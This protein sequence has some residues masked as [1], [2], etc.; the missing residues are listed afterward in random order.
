[1]L[2]K[3]L[4]CAII[5]F[6]LRFTLGA[7]RYTT[8]EDFESGFVSLSS[9]NAEEDVQPDAWTLDSATPDSSLYCL[10]LT[11]NCYKL[12][13]ITPY[14]IDSTGIIQV[15]VKTS[16]EPRI[17]G[18][19]FTDGVHNILY[20]FAG[21]RILDIEVWI[22]VYQGAFSSGV[23]NT[24]QLPVASDWEAFWGYLPVINGIIYI[25]DLDGIS[26]RSVWFDNIIDIS[27]DLPVAPA[28]SITAS[29]SAKNTGVF[30]SST[31]FDPD[32]DTFTY[33]WS[34]GDSTYS[35]LPNPYH[36]YAVASAYPYTV[37]LKV[38]DDT[39]KVGF[40]ATEV[41]LETGTS[42][43]PVTLNFVGDIMLARKYEYPGG[44][45]P[46]L[47][48]NAIFAP[49]KPYFGDAA[50]IN[51]AN[52]EVV[53]ANVG[54]H[55]PTKS[56]Y[57]RG[58]PANVN[59]LVY[60]GI[61]V[62][63][64]ANNHTMDYGIE[65]YQQMQGLLN[66]AGIQYSGCGANS[67]EAYLP[68]FYNCRG[69]NIA[70]L[71][72]SDRTGQYNN[73]Q[74][75]L[76]A[77]YNKPGF[78]YMTPYYVEQQLQAVEGVAD[79]KIVEMHGGSEYSLTPGAGYDKD[80]NPFLE[81]TEDEDY[82]YRNDVPHQWDIA[83]RH[84]AI[85]SGAD[86]VIVHHPHIIQGL[87]LYQNKLIAHSLG[88]FVFDLDYPETMPTMILYAD[89]Y[90]DGFRNFRIKPFYIDQYIPQ[91]TTGQLAVYILDYI[92]GRS[93]DF[94]TRVMVDKENLEARVLME[95]E[96][97]SITA[98]AFSSWQQLLMHSGEMS[99]TSPIK[100]PRRGSISDITNVEPPA[101]YQ[102]RLGQEHIWYGNFEN[103]GCNLWV[104]P[105]YST[106]DFIDGER[107]AK[108]TTTGD[109]SV[110]STISQ[111]CKIYD[112]T[113]K[114]TL[115]GWLKTENVTLANITI[116]FYTSRTA[117]V[118]SYTDYVTEDLTGTN[119]WTYYYRELNLPANVFYYEIRL[120]MTGS[121][122]LTATALFDNV[123]LIEWTQWTATEDLVNIPWPNNYYWIQA[124]TAETPKSMSF[125]L[126]ERSFG[127]QR[128][129]IPNNFTKVKPELKIS[130]NPFNPETVINCVLPVSGKTALK[131]YNIKGQLVKEL[132]KGELE[133]GSHRFNWNAKD[134]TNRSVGSGVYFIYLK[135]G[136][137]KVI[138]KAVLMK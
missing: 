117:A 12:Q 84:S 85:D 112:N 99:Y 19:G 6:G 101:E 54:V 62:V 87:E 138:R 45:I 106:T 69:L 134:N 100:L 67:Y 108:L 27:S 10:K 46:T 78:A 89:A 96:N 64:T 102:F 73:A 56:V 136:N 17:Q 32:S 75:F 42:G 128:A 49:S 52:L 86:L 110:T 107:S 95:D 11:G 7:V 68:T 71:S 39:G 13:Q 47:G 30:F 130:P 23:W 103:E 28:V 38:T 29:Y 33:E 98:N 118:P 91:P 123:G 88:N 113:K 43:L 9:W 124:R 26:S 40:A 16:S 92:A 82:F 60:A 48:V 51:V 132:F 34:F 93:R 76:Q 79:L 129:N 120:Q 18:I 25:N 74:P 55:H 114:Y 63:S 109:G 57:Y 36:L 127:V 83:I 14:A 37:T 104:P 135:N 21:T 94:N 115:H 15:Q 72:S 53:L 59:G 133:A 20:S 41:T 80:F 61:D 111:R 105:A 3:L 35:N 90:F 31:V 126:V 2:R 77:G 66:N 119:D 50:D 4:F 22:P 121:T 122:E 137:N 58:N 97:P 131:I 125:S 65:A 5:F 1:M 70:F 8:L 44:I 24:Y 116:R 81:D